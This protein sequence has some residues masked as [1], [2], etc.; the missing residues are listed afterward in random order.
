M[1][2]GSKSFVRY[3]PDNTIFRAMYLEISDT[4]SRPDPPQAIYQF[5]YMGHCYAEFLARTKTGGRTAVFLEP[6]AD[7]S[8]RTAF[9]HSITDR[10]A[11]LP[12]VRQFVMFVPFGWKQEG[13]LREIIVPGFQLTELL[14]RHDTHVLRF[15]RIGP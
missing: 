7:A 9:L 14:S 2:L 8:V 1:L 6:R 12:G 15:D 13:E 4:L 10:L 3:P 5:H 11:E